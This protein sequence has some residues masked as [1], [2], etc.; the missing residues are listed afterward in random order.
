MVQV[1][2]EEGAY[3]DIIYIHEYHGDLTVPNV[4]DKLMPIELCK[5]IQ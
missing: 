1:L 4:N 2:L 5:Q 3:T